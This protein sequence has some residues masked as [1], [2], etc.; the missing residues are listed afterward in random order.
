MKVADYEKTYMSVTH[1]LKD[2]KHLD[3]VVEFLRKQNEPVTCATIGEAVFGHD[4]HSDYLGK[5]C[6]GMMGQMLRHLQ[7]GG[8]VKREDHKGEPFEI[9]VQEFVR[10]NDDNGESQLITVHDDKGREFV[11]LNPNFSYWRS[12]GHYEKVKKTITPTIKTY[13]WVG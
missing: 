2:T 13:K 4:Y 1:A 6:Q 7:M 5:S 10:G 12:E 11:I 9:D 3:A 8:F